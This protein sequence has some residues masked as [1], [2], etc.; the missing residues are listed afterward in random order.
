MKT[1]GPRFVDGYQMP[2]ASSARLSRGS[3]I[4]VEQLGGGAFAQI[5]PLAGGRE[6]V[7]DVHGEWTVEGVTVTS[8][9]LASDELEARAEFVR[10]I[11]TITRERAAGA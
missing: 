4:R 9:Y 1:Y 11:R 8:S 2:R 5:T 3:P 10:L 6:R 7:F